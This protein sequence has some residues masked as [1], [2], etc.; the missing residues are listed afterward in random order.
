MPRL[1]RGL[2]ISYTKSFGLDEGETDSHL[3][4]DYWAVAGFVFY[5]A[6]V[7]LSLA[8]YAYAYDPKGTNNPRWTGIFG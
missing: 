3:Y 1:D 8:W 6:N 4:V 5:V 7:S 2:L